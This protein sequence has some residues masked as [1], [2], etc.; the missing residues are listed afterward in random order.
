MNATNF[1]LQTKLQLSRESRFVIKNGHL[2]GKQTD[3]NSGVEFVV[4]YR[5]EFATLIE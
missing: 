3:E 5:I 2:H 4:K 1:S